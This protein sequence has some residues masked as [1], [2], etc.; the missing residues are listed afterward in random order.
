MNK[1]CILI[2]LLL[3]FGCTEKVNEPKP[4]SPTPNS[5]T[6]DKDKPID[7]PPIKEETIDFSKFF[8]PTDTTAYFEGFGNEYASYTLK[9]TW[10]NDKYVA[11]LID[12]GGATVLYVYRITEKQ[13]ELVAKNIVD[14][15]IENFEYP[16]IEQLEGSP[17][18]E[19]YLLGPIEKGTKIAN[20]T[21]IETHA[22]LETPFKKF[23]NVFIIEEKGEGFTNRYYF[24][25]GYGEIKREAIMDQD[26]EN[27]EQ[28]IVTSTLKN[29][30][31]K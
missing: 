18:I 2:A 26:G 1:L 27:N 15:P 24:A 23:K 10:L 21:I 4:N 22:I 9:T 3:L 8:M 13:V 28:F 6:P 16:K 12:N 25:S 14:V 29:V 5:E 31:H 7:K 19:V 30:E 11:T 17:S 20:R